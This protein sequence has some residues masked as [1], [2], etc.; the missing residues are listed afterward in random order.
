MWY[1][2]VGDSDRDRGPGAGW[3]GRELARPEPCVILA[4]SA[5]LV[6]SQVVQRPRLDGRPYRRVYGELCGRLY[7]ERRA[8]SEPRLWQV[9]PPLAGAAS[10]LGW[11]PCI[12]PILASVLSVA[13]T[14]YGAGG[15]LVRPTYVRWAAAPGGA[16]MSRGARWA[17]M[18]ARLSVTGRAEP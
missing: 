2:L 12:G 6:G 3:P 1:L 9:A 15:A 14:L 13:A 7:G 8:H 18:P 11:T 10:G 16:G 5:F 4:M 17:A